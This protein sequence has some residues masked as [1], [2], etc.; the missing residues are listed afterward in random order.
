MIA[1]LAAMPLRMI[2]RGS[3]PREHDGGHP[4]GME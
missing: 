4:V 1:S 2:L 3:N